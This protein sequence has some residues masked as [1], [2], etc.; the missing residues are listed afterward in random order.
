M[1]ADLKLISIQAVT[2]IRTNIIHAK[3]GINTQHIYILVYI[4][5]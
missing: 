1:R 5:S 4:C 3:G 2:T